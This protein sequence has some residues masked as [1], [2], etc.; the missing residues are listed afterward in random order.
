MRV[1]VVDFHRCWW[2]VGKSLEGG[3]PCDRTQSM[4]PSRWSRGIAADSDHDA[5]IRG[6]VHRLN[7]KGTDSMAS[8]H[9]FGSP[10]P[11]NIPSRKK[12]RKRR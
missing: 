3:R 8:R 12:G 4:G 2:S 10:L 7:G 1:L 9:K 6:T 11:R 5:T